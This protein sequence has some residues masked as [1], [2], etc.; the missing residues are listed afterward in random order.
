M[1]GS[2]DDEGEWVWLASPAGR[3]T[4]RRAAS[5]VAIAVLPAAAAVVVMRRRVRRRARASAWRYRTY[6]EVSAENQRLV[7]AH[8]AVEPDPIGGP[9]GS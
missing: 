9:G 1:T 6:G 4:P 7:D 2:R 8:T 3:P 5:R